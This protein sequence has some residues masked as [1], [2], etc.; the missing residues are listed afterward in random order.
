MTVKISH[1]LTIGVPHFHH[2]THG[3]SR[4][5]FENYGLTTGQWQTHGRSRLM[6]EFPWSDHWSV[7]DPWKKEVDV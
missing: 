7:G 4:L 6:F 3:R 1:L 2:Q 5:M